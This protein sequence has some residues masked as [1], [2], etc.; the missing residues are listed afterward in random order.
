MVALAQ[1]IKNVTKWGLIFDH[2]HWDGKGGLNCI[3]SHPGVLC[4]ERTRKSNSIASFFFEFWK[5]K[6][7][8]V[9]LHKHLESVALYLVNRWFIW[10]LH[11]D[12]RIT[13]SG[14]V[15]TFL[16]RLYTVTR[17]TDISRLSEQVGWNVMQEKVSYMKLCGQ[18][19]GRSDFK[20][21]YNWWNN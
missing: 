12:I 20:Q 17:L 4:K 5:K 14:F 7:R 9:L 6:L 21:S 8:A 1:L 13:F 3:P 16:R 10:M 2:L 18:N 19:L 15:E 11:S